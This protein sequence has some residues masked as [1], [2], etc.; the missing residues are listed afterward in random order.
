VVIVIVFEQSKQQFLKLPRRH[1]GPLVEVV[2]DFFFL[3]GGQAV[4]SG[5]DNAGQVGEIAHQKHGRVL[6]V[7]VAEI[8]KNRAEII[9]HPC[10]EHQHVPG[11]VRRL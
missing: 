11:H 8:E 2:Q 1:V 10:A 6:V 9:Q 7:E 5:V 4:Q 3:P